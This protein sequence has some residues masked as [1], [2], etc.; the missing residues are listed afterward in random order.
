[1]PKGSKQFHKWKWRKR[2]YQ[3]NEDITP[4]VQVIGLQQHVIMNLSWAK[5]ADEGLFKTR[6]EGFKRK[7]RERKAVWEDMMKW[8]K[9][10]NEYMESAIEALTDE[11]RDDLKYAIQEIQRRMKRENAKGRHQWNGIRQK[12]LKLGSETVRTAAIAMSD[13]RLWNEVRG[14][15]MRREGNFQGASDDQDSSENDNQ[16]KLSRNKA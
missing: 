5:N 12:A 7:L 15:D 6:F 3:V 14:I 11:I 10:A 9:R 2:L 16:A 8:D 1:M 13:L 4:D